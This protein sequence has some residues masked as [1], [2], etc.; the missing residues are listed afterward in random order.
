MRASLFAFGLVVAACNDAT[1]T[2]VAPVVTG[3]AKL[4]CTKPIGDIVDRAPPSDWKLQ[5]K[6]AVIVKDG[7]ISAA[8]A[9]GLDGHVIKSHPIV[10]GNGERAAQQTMSLAICEAGGLV[11]TAA[12]ESPTEEEVAKTGGGA[13]LLDAFIPTSSNEKDDLVMLCREPDNAAKDDPFRRVAQ[14]HFTLQWLTSVKWRT[15]LRDTEES[16]FASSNEVDPATAKV[17]N[18]AALDAGN[19]LGAKATAAG[20]Q[21]CAYADALKALAARGK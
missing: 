10:S 19:D 1:P 7:Q 8:E 5:G 6:V 11:A 21:T 2:P 14:M 12:K 4:D 18:K 17:S 13:L 16:I 20:F 15:F 3:P 9:R